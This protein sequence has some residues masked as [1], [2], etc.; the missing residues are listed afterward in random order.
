MS[1]KKIDELWTNTADVKPEDYDFGEGYAEAWDIPFEQN[2]EEMDSDDF[3]PMMNYRYPLPDFDEKN[4]SSDKIKKAL[5]RAGS[6]TLVEDL[7][8]NEKFLALTGGGMDLSWDIV[9]G[10]VN[11]GFAPPAHFCRNLPEMAGMALTEENNEAILG[12]RRSLKVQSGWNE[13]GLEKLKD[14]EKTLKANLKR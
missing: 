3:F 12:C 10:Y 8:S 14:L 1:N 6:L 5:R 4:H 9:K 7:K 2:D 11:L 13:R